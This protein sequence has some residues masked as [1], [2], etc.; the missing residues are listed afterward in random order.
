MP[1]EWFTLHECKVNE[2]DDEETKL[3]KEFNFR[4]AAAK[5]PYFMTYVYPK[6]KAE[7][8]SYVRN[9]SKGA[10]RRFNEYGITSIDDLQAYQDKTPQMVEYCDFYEKL[11]P[12]GNNP[13]VVNRI[14]WI[15]E[16]NF[17]NY[18]S[19]I[20]KLL[21]NTPHSKFDYSLLKSGV[22]YSKN[23]YARIYLIYK[24]YLKKVE[25]YQKEKRTEKIDRFDNWLH[26]QAFVNYFRDEC[27]KVCPNENELCDIVLDICYKTEKSKQFAWFVCG[28]VILQN[29]LEKNNYQIQ[30]PLCVDT[31]GDFTY[32]G[33]QFKMITK[34]VE[35]EENDY[36]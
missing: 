11:M 28:R 10:I 9:N 33:K 13:C 1:A 35:V 27:Y 8:D 36:S 26:H 32:F 4:I 12:V 20:S 19:H 18:V 21:R 15:F 2:D 17:K 30:Y 29:L 14:S 22:S 25:T 16:R 6:L 24:D 23:D 31:D 7:N 5:K 34:Q 3:R